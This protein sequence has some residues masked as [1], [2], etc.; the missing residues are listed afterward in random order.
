MR[1]ISNYKPRLIYINYEKGR[2]E[3][4]RDLYQCSVTIKDPN[5]G[6]SRLQNVYFDTLLDAKEY[7]RDHNR[8]TITR[9]VGDMECAETY[10]WGSKEIERTIYE[11]I[12]DWYPNEN[13]SESWEDV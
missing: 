10:E 4:K 3:M 8:K 6:E 5:S 11:Q 13:N 1:L 12:W 2:C 9:I 7:A